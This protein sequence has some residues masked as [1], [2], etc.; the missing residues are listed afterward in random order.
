MLRLFLADLRNTHISLSPS[1]NVDGLHTRS[2]LSHDQVSE[3]HGNVFAEFC[4][5]CKKRYDRD[6]DV[7]GMGLKLTGRKCDDQ[8]CHGKLR[9]FVLDWDDV[10]P[11]NEVARTTRHLE[12]ADLVLCLGTSLRVAPAADL[13]E[14][15]LEHGGKMVLV[16]LQSTP[17]DDLASLLIHARCDDV[18]RQVIEKLNMKVSQSASKSEPCT[19]AVPGDS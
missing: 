18:M 12:D 2:G 3:L 13:P 8:K 14:R 4:D 15:V 5:K 17:K 19:C 1:Q 9:D 11:E 10:V 6:F 16:N 7:Q